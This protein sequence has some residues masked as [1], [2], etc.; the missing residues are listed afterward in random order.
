MILGERTTR[1]PIVVAVLAVWLVPRASLAVPK[2][3]DITHLQGSRTN[4]LMGIGLVVGL[5]GTGDGGRYASTIQALAR[6]QQTFGNPVVSL[7][8][9]KDTKNV[10]IVQ[11]DATLPKDGVREG[12][13]ID[14]MVSS[15]GPAKSLK[16]GRLVVTPLVGPNPEDT[17]GTMALASGPLKLDDPEV[18]TVARISQGATL[19]Q[20]WIHNYIVLGRELPPSVRTQPFIFAD[21]LYV[22]LVIDEPHAEWGV[23]HTIAQTINSDLGVGVARTGGRRGEGDA[24]D[25]DE[26]AT[27]VDPRTVVVRI[28]RIDR[29]NP[30]SF[31]YRLEKHPLIMPLTE[32]RVTIHRASG[33]IVISGAVEISPAVISHKGLTITTLVPPVK[34][35]PANPQLVEQRFVGLDPL[36]RGGAKLRDLVEALNQLQVP[37]EDRIT[38]IQKLHENG[39]LHATMIVED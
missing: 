21:E 11:V 2:V 32:A 12:E 24:N 38:I 3:G 28:P 26:M 13:R 17:R 20:N 14:V 37:A 6:L 18:P 5:P 19:E 10:A 25:E 29:H 36:N 30:A 34:P 33:T 8:Q 1:W 27:A 15:L 16:G 39:D 9:L 7:E 22:T 23:A 4:K 35:N 31:I